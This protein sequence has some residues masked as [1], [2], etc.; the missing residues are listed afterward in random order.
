MKFIFEQVLQ[1]KIN[2]QRTDCGFTPKLNVNLKHLDV[3][4]HM[5]FPAAD[6]DKIEPLLFLFKIALEDDLGLIM[7][8]ER[9]NKW[10]RIVRLY[11]RS[12]LGYRE[13]LYKC[14]YKI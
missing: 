6:I 10:G 11:T 5:A 1:K 13:H 9:Y 2:A 14:A 7:K 3:K 4:K 12:G 8:E